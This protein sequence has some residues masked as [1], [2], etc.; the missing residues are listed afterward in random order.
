[1]LDTI[2]CGITDYTAANKTSDS[3]MNDTLLLNKRSTIALRMR[4]TTEQEPNIAMQT[5]VMPYCNARF[6][7]NTP[8][9]W[10]MPMK[11]D[12]NLDGHNANMDG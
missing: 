5:P 8:N 6:T 10:Q 2:L 4:T 3:P 9:D 11:M 12:Q 7:P 1:M